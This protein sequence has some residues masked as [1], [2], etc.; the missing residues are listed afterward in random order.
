[1]EIA[2]ARLDALHGELR[3]FYQT[4]AQAA[5]DAEM[6]P[7]PEI[8][9]EERAAI[10]SYEEHAAAVAADL[11]KLVDLDGRRHRVSVAVHRLS[12]RWVPP[13][14]P[15]YHGALAQQVKLPS[16]G[17]GPDFWPINPYG[18]MLDAAARAGRDQAALAEYRGSE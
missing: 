15:T 6:A 17:D 2:Q 12:G 13:D 7:I 4:E 1:M 16:A 9:A 10:R 3:R 14:R 18:R 5:L 11:A 8:D